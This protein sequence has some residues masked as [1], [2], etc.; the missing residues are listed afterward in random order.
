[1]I[2]HSDTLEW[3]RHLGQQLDEATSQ[4]AAQ[5]VVAAKAKHELEVAHATAFL[6][7]EG[8]MDVRKQMSILDTAG[9]RL[10]SSLADVKVQATLEHIRSLRVRIEVGRSLNAAQRTDAIAAGL[11]A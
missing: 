6:G 3:L 8:P 10:A 5:L 1:M 7:N 11:Q 9:H 2:E 4:L